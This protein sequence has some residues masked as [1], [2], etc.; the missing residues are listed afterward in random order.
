MVAKLLL[1]LTIPV[2]FFSCKISKDPQRSAIKQLQRGKLKDDTSFIYQLPYEKNTPILVVQGYY[3]NFSHQNRAAIDFKMKRGAKIF[4]ARGGVVVR[5]KEDGNKGGLKKKYRPYGN[6]II[7]QHNDGS[8]AGYWHLQFNSAFV[9]L[10][11]TVKQGQLIGL[12]GKTGFTLFPHLHFI[13]WRTSNGKWQQVATRFQTS[14]GVLFL[15]PLRRY[16][17]II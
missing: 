9:N 1:L 4:A 3:S 15:R 17:R 8:R 11:D 6:I 14:K 12:N 16:K 13:V 7:I 5:A 2:I 10:G